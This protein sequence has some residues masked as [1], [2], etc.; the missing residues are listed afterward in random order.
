MNK[1][2]R[3]GELLFLSVKSIPK[4]LKETQTNEIVRGSHGNSHTFKGGKIYFTQE[5]NFTFGYFKADNTKLYHPEHGENKVRGLLE[6]S[7]SN[8]NYQLRKQVEFINKQM[9]QVVD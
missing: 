6:A 4:G 5:D 1:A 2:Y 8:G 7:L 9:V 3:H